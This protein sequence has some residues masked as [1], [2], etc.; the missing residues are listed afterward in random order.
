MSKQTATRWQLLS[1]H[2]AF[3]ALTFRQQRIDGGFELFQA[4]TAT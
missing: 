4:N 2:V 3:E 1:Q